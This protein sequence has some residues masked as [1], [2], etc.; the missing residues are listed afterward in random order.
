MIVGTRGI[1]TNKHTHRTSFVALAAETDD[2][3]LRWRDACQ[4]RE[5]ELKQIRHNPT[6]D[7]V[8]MFIEYFETTLELFEHQSF[9]LATKYAL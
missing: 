4:R 9:R 5:R 7:F 6:G 1:R 8:H 2:E 3:P